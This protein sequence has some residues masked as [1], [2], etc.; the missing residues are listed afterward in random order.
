VSESLLVAILTFLANILSEA[1][2]LSLTL[3]FVR[4]GTKI[5]TALA[6][7]SEREDRRREAE[8]DLQDQLAEGR[9]HGYSPRAIGVQILGSQIMALRAAIM[10]GASMTVRRLQYEVWG[11]SVL[12]GLRASLL[13]NRTPIRWGAVVL[14]YALKQDDRDPA[15]IKRAMVLTFLWAFELVCTLSAFGSALTSKGFVGATVEGLIGESTKDDA[16]V[17]RKFG[18]A[19]S[20]I[21]RTLISST[22]IERRE[23]LL[24]RARARQTLAHLNV[25]KNRPQP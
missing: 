2:T 6:L 24:S 17:T 3:K 5:Y 22:P 12:V 15:L 16:E 1:Y 11:L 8:S 25:V 21:V 20:G 10:L 4:R 18:R 23:R 14:S 13:A 19:I 7:P 9:Q